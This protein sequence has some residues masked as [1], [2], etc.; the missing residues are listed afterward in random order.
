M[1]GLVPNELS[2]IAS[3][4]PVLG[5]INRSS[6]GSRFTIP[7]PEPLQIPKSAVNISVEVQSSTIWW[8]IPNIITGTNDRLYISQAGVPYNI[9]IPQGLYDLSGLNNAI[10]VGLE[11]IGAPQV[12]GALISL[13]PDQATQK[14]ILRMNYANVIVD[15]TQPSTFRQILGF[16]SQV[17]NNGIVVPFNY[18]ADNTAAFNTVNYFL[19]HS[20]LCYTGIRVNGIGNQT[21]AQVLIDKAPG[22][23]IVYS[24]YNPARIPAPE[25]NGAQRNQLSFWLTNDRNQAVNTN[26]D[27]WSVRVVIRYFTPLVLQ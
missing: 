5:A 27:E 16:N 18:T 4:D 23:Q 12:N 13:L 7:L 8:S 15:F 3:S 19:I 2:F 25:L 9:T 1:S 14:V 10:S 22:S 17:L 24:P 21:I 26:G 20:D 11:N 6:D